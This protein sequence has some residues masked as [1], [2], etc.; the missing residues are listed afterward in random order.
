MKWK[1]FFAVVIVVVIFVILAKVKF[2]QFGAMG[3]FGKSFVPPPDS[4]SSAVAQ[5]E[6]WQDTLNAVGSV[7]AAQG[8]IVSPE[9]A[10][11]VTEID[12]ESGAT[13]AKGDLLVKLDSSTEE[14]QL[15]AADAQ[16]ELAKLNADRARKLRTD[17]TVSQSEL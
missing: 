13:V 15:I 1:I 4:V 16:V 7:N 17:N 3:A 14:A 5:E 8:V 2:M 6:K 12:F 9:I 11:T 10:G